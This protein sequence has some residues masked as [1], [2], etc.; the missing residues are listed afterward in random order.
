MEVDHL[1]KQASDA[2]ETD[3]S[4]T[5]AGSSW[6]SLLFT[7]SIAEDQLES[8]FVT[9]EDFCQ[10]MKGVQPSALREGFATVPNV[11]WDQVGALSE[12]RSE[13]KMSILV[14]I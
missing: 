13:L 12:I 11:T 5:A 6:W 1:T 3:S 4:V 10:A 8:L 7:Q 2:M 9:F 14:S